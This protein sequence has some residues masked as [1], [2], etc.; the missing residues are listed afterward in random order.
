MP[1][2]AIGTTAAPGRMT[3]RRDD[4]TPLAR[5]YLMRTGLVAFGFQRLKS[6]PWTD[7]A[8][9]TS[10]SRAMMTRLQIG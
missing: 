5:P 7:S 6:R 8:Q 2:S 10:T 9:I 4:A 3:D 1:G